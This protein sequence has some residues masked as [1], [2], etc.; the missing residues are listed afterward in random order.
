M[1]TPTASFSVNVDPT[2]PG[3]FFACCGLLELADRLWPNA[4][5]WFAEDGLMF[6]VA[7]GEHSL[8]EL[9]NAVGQSTIQSSLGDD[10]LKR[11]GTLLSV[12]KDSLTTTDRA[13]KE[14][15]QQ[16]W[17]VERVT[18][19]SPFNIMLDWWWDESSGVTLLKTWAAKQFV[20]EIAR[21]MLFAIRATNWNLCGL[22]NCLSTTAKISGL[23]FYFDADNNTQ[24]TPRDF[25]VAPADVKMAPSD[26][27]LV[28][29]L[30]FIAL[31]RFRPSRAGRS[32]LVQY[33]IWKA[34]QIPNVAAA[35]ATGCVQI[36][37]S[38]KFEFR[39][40]Y[41]TKY[42]KAFLPSRPVYS[43]GDQQ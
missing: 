14:R 31:Q 24:N 2:N 10:G 35:L 39:M 3:Q 13:D 43:F 33:A 37:D 9:L 8:D 30:T 34:P 15:L 29:L 41:R 42:M 1:N 4:E 19:T 21:P 27:P 26:R 17:R 7:C 36:P 6:H 32:E 11:L 12:A 28:E 25:G 23:P 22:A 16:A 40:L 5:G 18:L 38:C 20:L